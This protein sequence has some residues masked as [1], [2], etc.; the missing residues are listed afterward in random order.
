MQQGVLRVGIVSSLT[1]GCLAIL[2]PARSQIV[3]DTTVP[4][5]TLPTLA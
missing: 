1:L 3:P 5:D 2:S 4:I